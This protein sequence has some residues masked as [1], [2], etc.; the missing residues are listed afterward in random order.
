[1]LLQI[2]FEELSAFNGEQQQ[3]QQANASTNAGDGWTDDLV[4][5]G[6]QDE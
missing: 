1:M 2:F 5:D 3:K 6:D 4:M